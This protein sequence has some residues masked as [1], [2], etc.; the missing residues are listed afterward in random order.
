MVSALSRTLPCPIAADTH[1]ADSR[2]RPP[3]PAPRVRE[4]LAQAQ[5]PRAVAELVLHGRQV[6]WSVH[7]PRRRPIGAV[8]THPPRRLLRHHHRLLARAD[9]RH[10]RLVRVRAVP[11]DR[12]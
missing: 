12:W 5:A 3:Q 6:P 4:A 2:R 9:R 7:A 1:A 11:A 8:L 10:L